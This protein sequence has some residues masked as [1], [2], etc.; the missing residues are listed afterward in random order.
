[1][2]AIASTPMLARHAALYMLQ[3]ALP[4]H[5]QPSLDRLDKYRKCQHQRTVRIHMPD[6][7]LAAPDRSPA[8][9]ISDAFTM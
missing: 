1:M 8:R 7:E 9:N 4:K 6:R 3:G 2:K 5:G